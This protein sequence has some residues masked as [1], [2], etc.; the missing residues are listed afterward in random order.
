MGASVRRPGQLR[1]FRDFASLPCKRFALFDSLTVPALHS[2]PDTVGFKRSA[3]REEW[4][5]HV[6]LYDAG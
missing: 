6:T 2:R 1:E 4:V 3:R 5:E